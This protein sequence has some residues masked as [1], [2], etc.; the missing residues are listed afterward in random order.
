[1]HPELIHWRLI[2]LL[3]L[4]LLKTFGLIPGAMAAYWVRRIFQ[5][6]RQQRAFEGWPTTEASIYSCK[7]E[8]EGPR[9]IWAEIAYTY[10][11]GEYRSGTYLRNFRREQD[12]DEFVR[13]I[14]DRR[15]QIRFKE[16]DPKTST[17]LDRDLE[18]LVPMSLSAR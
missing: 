16:S 9:R 3:V 7:V 18:L 6:W 17:I 5:K 11:V 12:A 8:H 1:M 14:K 15:V 4:K 10:F 13:Q 2:L